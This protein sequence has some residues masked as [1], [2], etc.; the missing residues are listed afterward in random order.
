M[1]GH[2]SS[3]VE[4][5]KSLGKA[6]K[7]LSQARTMAKRMPKKATKTR[8]ARKKRRTTGG[9]EITGGKPKKRRT[10]KKKTGLK[11]TRTRKR[12]TASKKK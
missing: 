4:V 9:D 7:A 5:L 8:T 3:V 10:T 12:R 2:R 6:E 1:T 11:V